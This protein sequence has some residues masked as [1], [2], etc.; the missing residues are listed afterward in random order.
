[1]YNFTE[2]PIVDLDAML[3]VYLHVF[4]VYL[5]KRKVFMGVLIIRL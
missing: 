1:M 2:F 4:V 5:R 3:Q